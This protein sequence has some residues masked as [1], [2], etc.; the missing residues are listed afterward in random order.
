MRFLSYM[1]NTLNNAI[2]LKKTKVQLT[3]FN[4]FILNIL[5]ILQR[6]NIIES[7]LVN[8]TYTTCTVFFTTSTS[9]NYF[10]KIICISKANRLVYMS[11]T[12]L[13]KL[14]SVDL[15]NDYILSINDTSHTIINIDEAI[16]KHTGGLLSAAAYFSHLILE[17]F[18]DFDIIC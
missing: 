3:K 14:R 8:N 13:Q 6:L 17:S 12:D 2:L 16:R 9:N 11:L 18:S 10:Q 4:S 7:F 15:Y 1:V 5:T